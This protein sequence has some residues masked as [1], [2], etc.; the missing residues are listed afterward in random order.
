MS[1]Q[2]KKHDALKRESISGIKNDTI[3]HTIN[4]HY[5]EQNTM[6]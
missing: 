3:Y 2:G 1:K 5:K 4:I 6:L